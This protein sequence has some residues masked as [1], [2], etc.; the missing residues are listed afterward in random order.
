MFDR[1]RADRHDSQPGYEIADDQIWSQQVILMEDLLGQAGRQRTNPKGQ[2]F[3]AVEYNLPKPNFCLSAIRTPARILIARPLGETAQAVD[4]RYR[5]HYS[6][7]NKV[8]SC[9]INFAKN[10][11][12]A[13]ANS[14]LYQVSIKRANQ[15][16]Y[17]PVSD[18]QATAIVA[19]TRQA[20]ADL[21]NQASPY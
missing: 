13:V 21:Y 8:L 12:D 6:M 18:N 3:Q 7:E 1:L 4:W 20:L 17:M 9:M 11:Q 14:R 19:D 16:N 10:D 5:I 15:P 2:S